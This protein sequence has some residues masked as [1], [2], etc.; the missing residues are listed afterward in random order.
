MGMMMFM[1]VRRSGFVLYSVSVMVFEVDVEFDTR[2]AGLLA[3][4]DLEMVAADSQFFQFGVQLRRIYSQINER[5]DKHVP[6]DPAEDIEVK[7]FH[8]RERIGPV[9]V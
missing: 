4:S 7:R 3:A 8:N 9:Q 5:A 2:D 1:S 6:A